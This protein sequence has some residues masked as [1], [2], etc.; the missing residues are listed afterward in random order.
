M[1]ALLVAPRVSWVHCSVFT[2]LFLA[3][4]QRSFR[5]APLGSWVA[6]AEE[7]KVPGRLH[8]PGTQG[9]GLCQPSLGSIDPFSLSFQ[10]LS[11]L[12]G[13][14]TN[15]GKESG[16]FP[17]LVQMFADHRGWIDLGK[18][19][20]FIG[21]K[22]RIN[23]KRYFYSGM[24]IC[25][26]CFAVVFLPGRLPILSWFS[27]RPAVG[28]PRGCVLGPCSFLL[29]M[30]SSYR[31]PSSCS[32]WS[33]SQVEHHTSPPNT[34]TWVV[35]WHSKYNVFKKQRKLFIKN[36]LLATFFFSVWYNC[37]PRSPALRLHPPDHSPQM[38][39]P[40]PNTR[41]VLCQGRGMKEWAVVCTSL[42]FHLFSVCLELVETL[43]SKRL[44][45]LLYFFCQLTSL[46][47][48]TIHHTSRFHE[49]KTGKLHWLYFV[50][51]ERLLDPDT[52]WKAV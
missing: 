33:R 9:D 18:R 1:R 21:D 39:W 24:S 19:L 20:P 32:F 27:C 6:A 44:W 34:S 37:F 45:S 7:L 26:C 28:I 3:L 16:W 17:P 8:L 11:A 2:S 52:L 51:R 4:F 40:P 23:K 47:F 12:G 46:E 14:P 36:F 29:T 15:F 22:I 35:Y 25:C 30:I 41:H 10:F 5:E 31:S 38:E 49:R 13:L 48:I 43:Y 50:D 42:F